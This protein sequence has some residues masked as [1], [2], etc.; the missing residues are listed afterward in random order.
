MSWD[1]NNLMFLKVGY[2][3]MKILLESK[4]AYLELETRKY[5]SIFIVYESFMN[6]LKKIITSYKYVL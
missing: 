1:L 2:K 5:K 3:L 4:D 6:V